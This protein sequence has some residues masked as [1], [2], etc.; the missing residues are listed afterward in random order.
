MGYGSY[1]L[2]EVML[3]LLSAYS[4]VIFL[5]HLGLACGLL[6][7]RLR[8][9][10]AAAAEKP[11]SPARV[12]VVVAAK[13]EERLLPLLLSSLEKQ[14]AE[15]FEIVLINDRSGDRT[16][17]IMEGF[18]RKHGERVKVV[19]NTRDPVAV[20][21][22]Q[23]ALDYGLRE[24]S[25]DV[26]LFTDSDC[27]LPETW[28]EGL[29][30]Y[31]DNPRTGT[32]FGQIAVKGSS[33]FLERYQWFDQALIHQYSSGTAGLGLPTS[34][35]GNNLGARRAVLDDVGGFRALG[36]TLTEDAAL[37]SKAGK[38]G[39]KVSVS[40]REDTT[41]LTAPQD[42]WR[43]FINQ[44]VRWNSGG[45]FSEDLVTR[46]GYR[47]I[48]LFLMF[49]TLV[50]P[51]ASLMPFL[52]ILPVTSFISIGL[53]ALLLGLLYA[54]G[55]S[56]YLLRL[57]PNTLFFMLFYSWITLL[58]LIRVSPEWKGRKLRSKAAGA[59]ARAQEK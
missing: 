7:N 11:L 2:M 49:S 3:Y 17:E 37:I 42:S 19:H 41:I 32:V 31:F 59:E 56:A 9:L 35:F 16:G 12:S 51:F 8:D 4:L 23:A 57:V 21:P 13:D 36:Y 10:R 29:L 58:C 52:L 45:F 1:M 43:R 33:S 25:G 44:H 6:L 34:C 24:A 39:W 54:P 55:K 22:K 46:L 50:L 47:T 18:R 30:R 5:I 14:T 48:V 40:T 27:E 38:K 53:I 15:E 20:N 26:L 28:V